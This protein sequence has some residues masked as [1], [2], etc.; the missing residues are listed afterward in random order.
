VKAAVL[1][2]A[3]LLVAAGCRHKPTA[4]AAPPP[5]PAIAPAA[6][7]GAAATGNAR[8]GEAGGA[9]V[10]TVPGGN[11][12]LIPQG[13]PISSEVGVASWYGTPYKGR[14]ASDGSVYDEDAMTAA[15]RT[16]PLG[17]IVRVTNLTNG[18]QVLVRI[19]DR[20]PFVDGRII[21]LSP[22]AAKAINMYRAGISKVRLEAYGP[23]A[24][25]DAAGRWCV[26]I[27][28]F[29][30]PADALQLKNDLKRRYA[31]AKV[32]EFASSTGHWVRIDPKVDD[33]ATAE[34][35]ADSIHIPDPNAAP[36]VIRLN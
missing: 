19:T 16:L 20:G 4:V 32:I 31:S 7:A 30:D 1:L 35:I 25:S 23:P 21:D 15:H 34:E 12:L 26:Q 29:L 14:K 28:A 17:S 5:P 22:A 10:P 8:P 2:P 6:G 33:R 3:L 27:G 11:E 9:A 13:P 18:Q 24:G 36:Y